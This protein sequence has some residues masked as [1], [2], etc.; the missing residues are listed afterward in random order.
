MTTS[1][2]CTT[3]V[4]TVTKCPPEV[5]NCPAGGYVTTETIPLYTTVC[6]VTAK[7]TPTQ[8]AVPPEYETKTVYTTS[9][10]T[11]TKCPPEVVNCPV[12]SVTTE[13]IP[14]YTT[15]CPVTEKPQPVPTKVPGHSETKTLYTAKIYTPTECPAGD[16]DCVVGKPTTEVA[17]WTTAIVPPKETK[18]VQVYHPEVP[19]EEEEVTTVKASYTVYTNVVVP[20]ATLE[21][22]I[23]PVVTERPSGVAAPTGGCSGPGCPQ[24]TAVHTPT[25]KKPD[26]AP[27]TPATAG[28]S[29]LVAGLTAVVGAVLFQVFVL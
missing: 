15:V 26:Y 5:V 12:G 4:Y 21:T 14:V 22:T 9:V 28:A 1:T 16:D 3:K 8:Y 23:K 20:P 6:P 2:V 18:P 7:A 27:I 25:P 11:V 13:T 24:P 17:S 29:S 19:E 10:H